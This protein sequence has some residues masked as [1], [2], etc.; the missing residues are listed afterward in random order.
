[1]RQPAT[2]GGIPEPVT[3][4]EPEDSVVIYHG[5]PEVLANGKGALFTILRDHL[6]DEVAVVDFSTGEIRVLVEG[7]LGRYTESG[8]LVYV[9]EDGGLMAVP[10]DQDRFVVTRPELLLSDQLSPGLLPELCTFEVR[11]I[12]LHAK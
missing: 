11:T 1:M 6:A 4:A 8:H 10:F 7:T 12:A 2:G 5:W 3:I 9:R